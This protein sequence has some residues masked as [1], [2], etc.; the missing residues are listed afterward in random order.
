MRES[1]FS[2]WL[3]LTKIEAKLAANIEMMKAGAEEG[4]E[5]DQFR[6]F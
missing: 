3:T 4:V 1:G 2:R 5:T 6:V